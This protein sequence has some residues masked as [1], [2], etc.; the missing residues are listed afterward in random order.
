MNMEQGL[1]S[2]EPAPEELVVKAELIPEKSFDDDKYQFTIESIGNEEIMISVFNS[3]SGMTYKT[4]IKENS[5]WYKSNIYIFKGEFSRVISI[6]KD[7]LINDTEIFKHNEIESDHELKVS[8]NYENEVFPFTLDIV[9]PKHVSEKGPL[10]DKVNILEYQVKQLTRK[11]NDS[12]KGLILKEKNKI[13]NE[14]GNLIYQGGLNDGKRHGNGIEYSPLTGLNKYKGEFKEGYYDG[15]GDWYNDSTTNQKIVYKAIF[16]KGVV[17]SKINSYGYKA[18][19][20]MYVSESFTLD[21]NKLYLLGKSFDEYG[22]L[23]LETNYV[24]GKKEGQEKAYYNG[25]ISGLN[26]Y[27]NGIPN[28]TQRAYYVGEIGDSWLQLQWE[29]KAGIKDGYC[30]QYDKGG[31]MIGETKYSNGEVIPN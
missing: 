18:C 30:R 11:L 20:D 9:I 16:R 4:K 17:I 28:G 10:E 15:E 14:V 19:G 8:I 26:N 6:L 2:P 31:S 3:Q 24:N 5:S 13:Y 21:E 23:T 7:S 29:V 27:V 1:M 12:N 25:K 22:K